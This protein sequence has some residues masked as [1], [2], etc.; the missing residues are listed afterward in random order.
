MRISRPVAGGYFALM[1]NA[2]DL[3]T[4]PDLTVRIPTLKIT[5]ITII[6]TAVDGCTVG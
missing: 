6:L 5:T 2:V 4:H 3:G 1:F